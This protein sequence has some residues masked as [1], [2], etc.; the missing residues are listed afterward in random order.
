MI[1]SIPS[2]PL[3]PTDS[4]LPDPAYRGLRILRVQS[5]PAAAS[6][7]M[8]REYRFLHE[9]DYNAIKATLTRKGMVT[10]EKCRVSAFIHPTLKQFVNI[11]LYDPSN[12]PQENYE[13]LGMSEAHKQTQSDFQ[14]QKDRNKY[15]FRDYLI[16]GVDGS[17]IPYL[18]VISGWQTKIA[19]DKTVFVTFDEEDPD[20]MYGFLYL[21]KLPVMQADGQTQTAA[22]FALHT[23]KDAIKK[24][25][26]E[27]FRITLEIELNV[28]ER[29]AGQSFA[30]RNGRGSK[31]NKNLVI[32]LDT[33]SALSDLRVKSITGTVFD[34]RLAHGRSTSTTET[35]TKYIV[36]LSTIEQMFMR[37]I[38]DGNEKPES[39][40]HFHIDHFAKYCREFIELLDSLFA[41]DWVEKTPANQDPFRRL[42]VHG[43]PFALKAIAAAYHRSRIDEIGPLAAALGARRDASKTFEEEFLD[44]L[45]TQ[46]AAWQKKPP[47]PFDELKARLEE[48]DWLR[49]RKHWIDLTGAK[50]KDGKKRTFKLKST[51][52]EKVLGQAQNTPTVISSVRDKILSETWRDLT[53][54]DDELF[55]AASASSSRRRATPTDRNR[56][57]KTESVANEPAQVSTSPMAS[58]S[59]AST[60]ES[61]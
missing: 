15:N 12:P 19:M 51:A 39:F 36:D 50:M 59:S 28:D 27:N 4:I 42:Y 47:V 53:G 29:Q 40:K 46:R 20:A 30:D 3:I 61:K 43:W 24:G 2:S 18:P 25:A 45:A 21:P 37:V 34:G 22:L 58:A 54:K 55:D 14:G 9:P 35:A 16:E 41:K 8:Q 33:S 52:E 44:E 11:I 17:R 5:D 13:A 32:A 60:Q 57:A 23:K 31:K 56:Q 26:L 38:A 7:F 10:G 1:P 49:Y 48:I 6:R